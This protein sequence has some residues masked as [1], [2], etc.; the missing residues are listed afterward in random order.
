LIGL[1]RIRLAVF[2]MAGTT[3]DDSVD[4]APLVLRSYDEAFRRHGV[5]VPMATL[6]EMR[7]RDKR[8]VIGELG[9]AE[10]SAI[11]RD[12]VDL[13]LRNAGR[14]R[15]VEGASGVF[16]WLKERGAFVAVESGFPTLVSYEVVKGMGWLRDGLVDYWTCS[17]L[18][19]EE[20]RL[21]VRDPSEV[22]KVDD[23]AVG[24]E[25]GRNA[26]AVTVGVLTGTQSRERLLAAGPDVVLPSVRELPG[27]LTEKGLI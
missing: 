21:G 7:G 9:G 13:L 19:D 6:N 25:E 22:V 20:R 24:V 16:R 12:F 4:G 23:T 26:G 18:V 17:E 3:V 8:A 15:E 2:D 1:P 11:Y 10:A 5:E 14:L 27:W